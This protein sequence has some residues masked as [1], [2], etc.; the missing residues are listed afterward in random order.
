MYVC[1]VFMCKISNGFCFWP[2]MGTSVS[3]SIA[4]RFPSFS[5]EKNLFLL[6][7][8]HAPCLVARLKQ[9]GFL[10]KSNWKRRGRGKSLAC[11]PHKILH[12]GCIWPALAFVC[13]CACQCVSGHTYGC[14]GL[15]LAFVC[16]CVSMCVRAYIRVCV[17][18][19]VCVCVRACVRACVHVRE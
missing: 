14:V 16:V 19:C 6:T 11:L 12:Y 9:E 17:C 4:T 5:L 18:V 10:R 7:F 8:L 15:P 3:D 1:I 13:V 2:H